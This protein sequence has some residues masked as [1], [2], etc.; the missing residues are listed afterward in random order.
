MCATIR[1]QCPIA[2]YDFL[3]EVSTAAVRRVPFDAVIKVAQAAVQLGAPGCHLN[4]PGSATGKG[5]HIEA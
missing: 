2:S 4:G 5:L 3:L 1:S